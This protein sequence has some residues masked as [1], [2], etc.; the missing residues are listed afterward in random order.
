[1]FA[2]ASIEQHLHT[3]SIVVAVV[4]YDNGLHAWSDI[5]RWQGP[6]KGLRTM[7]AVMRTDAVTLNPSR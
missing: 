4:N 2:A 5:A 7:A 1:M 3:K 6:E